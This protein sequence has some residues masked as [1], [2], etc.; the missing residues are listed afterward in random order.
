MIYMNE[1]CK[2]ILQMLLNQ[3]SYL[4]PAQIAEM[5]NVS[6]RSIY[7][8]IYRINDWLSSYKVSELETV[9]GK[10]ILLSD[11][12]K[13]AIEEALK[14]SSQEEAYIYSPMERIPIIYC[15]ILYEENPTY[16]E[17]LM[18]Y[19]DV[20]RNTIFNDLKV[21]E[22]QLLNYDL[23]LQYEAKTGYYIVGGKAIF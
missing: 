20:S 14:D 15:S 4:Q 23:K 18:E 22:S 11:S 16:I 13:A 7:Y 3:D 2:A 17:Q 5:L 19:C 21:M 8:D 10:G 9:R 1:R 6:K 12:E